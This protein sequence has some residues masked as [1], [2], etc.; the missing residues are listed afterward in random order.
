MNKILLVLLGVL[1]LTSCVS[2]YQK[3]DD[4]FFNRY[5]GGYS[6]QQMSSDE[7]SVCYTGSKDDSAEIW[8][9]A[10]G[11]GRKQI[12]EYA[13]MRAKEVTREH[14]YRYFVVLAENE[15]TKPG[16]GSAAYYRTVTLHIKCYREN[17]PEGAID[18]KIPSYLTPDN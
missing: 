12:R 7:F 6:E 1:A 2:S 11:K 3:L 5:K 8:E 16:D 9:L 13:Y 14:H 4:S 15:D 10:S 18:C 17:P